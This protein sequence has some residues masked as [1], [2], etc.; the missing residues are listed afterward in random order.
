[1][2]RAHLLDGAVPSESNP[3]RPYPSLAFLQNSS[4]SVAIPRHPVTRITLFPSLF[5]L[6][7]TLKMTGSDNA[8]RV[9]EGA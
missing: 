3:L 6:H 2:R 1:M 7:S 9:V 4:L 8:N 5:A